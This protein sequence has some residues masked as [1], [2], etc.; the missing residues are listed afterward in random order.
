M[1]QRDDG[2]YYNAE[3]VAELIRKMEPHIRHS[4]NCPGKIG[5]RCE[6]GSEDARREAARVINAFEKGS[7]PPPTVQ[8]TGEVPCRKCGNTHWMHGA[9]PSS[10]NDQVVASA[11]PDARP[12]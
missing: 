5:M 4:L 3:D 1:V 7:E 9:C 6:C 8:Y 2:D 11:A 12:D 10:Q